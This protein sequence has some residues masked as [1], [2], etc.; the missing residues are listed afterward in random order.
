MAKIT[1]VLMEHVDAKDSW[2]L[3]FY[4]SK[5][6]YEGVKK[7]L[8]DAPE[9]LIQFVKD[10]GPAR[11]RRRGFPDRHEVGLP[12]QEDRTSRSTSASTPT[13]ASPAR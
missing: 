7:A 6:G 4:K 3:D 8:D 13:S 11:P 5:G 9:E 2:T 10:S 12:G 1:P